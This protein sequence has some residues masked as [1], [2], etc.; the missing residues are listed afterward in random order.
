M[1]VQSF[2]IDVVV[3]YY[4]DGKMLPLYIV[5]DNDIKYKI[6]KITQIQTGA[7]MKYGLQGLRYTCVIQSQLR[8]LYFDGERWSISPIN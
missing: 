6:D 1:S 5:W 2:N 4:K 8:H 3:K 7:S